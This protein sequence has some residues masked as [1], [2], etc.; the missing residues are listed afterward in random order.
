MSQAADALGKL[1][2]QLQVP[3]E[4][5]WERIPGWTDDDVQR[6]KELV[7]SGSLIQIMQQLLDQTGG[8]TGPSQGQGDVGPS[9]Q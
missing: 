1:A 8:D 5:L 2:A 6:A 7:E 4:M 3:I 9:A